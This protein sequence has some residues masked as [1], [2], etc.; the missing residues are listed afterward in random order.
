MRKNIINRTITLKGEL[1]EMSGDGLH[2]IAEIKV[3]VKDGILK[4]ICLQNNIYKE[5]I[6]IEKINLEK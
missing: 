4:V 6:F 3:D 1:V 2:N 5:I